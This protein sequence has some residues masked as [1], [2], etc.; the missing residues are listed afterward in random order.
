M[1]HGFGRRFEVESCS[2]VKIVGPDSLV[3]EI[4]SDM[5]SLL[6]EVR[7]QAA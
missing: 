2:V 5:M 6:R 3:E 4:L 1:T 7:L